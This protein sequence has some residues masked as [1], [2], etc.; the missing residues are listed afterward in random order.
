MEL[1]SQ[2]LYKPNDKTHIAITT[3]PYPPLRLLRFMY[4]NV[5]QNPTNMFQLINCQFYIKT[6]PIR[7]D[8]QEQPINKRNSAA[9]RQIAIRTTQQMNRKYDPGSLFNKEELK[10]SDKPTKLT[11]QTEIARNNNI[12]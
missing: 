3:N 6:N 12:P 1:Q 2:P 8:N 7:N 11:E 5:P 9:L 4:L 10:I